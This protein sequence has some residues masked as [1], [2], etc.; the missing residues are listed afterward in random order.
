MTDEERAA[1]KAHIGVGQAQPRD[2]I[3]TDGTRTHSWKVTNEATGAVGGTQ[4]EH[5]SGRLDATVKPPTLHQE[6]PRA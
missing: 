4:T 2:S 6:I 5:R 1:W 3:V